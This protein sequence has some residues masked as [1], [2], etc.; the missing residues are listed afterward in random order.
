MKLLQLFSVT[1]AKRVLP[2]S[3]MVSHPS[4]QSK[5]TREKKLRQL[6]TSQR[7]RHE[8]A[9]EPDT[10]T[11]IRKE[12]MSLFSLSVKVLIPTFPLLNVSLFYFSAAGKPKTFHHLF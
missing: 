4:W 3:K 1:E 8:Q 5:S 2:N 12:M 11:E 9:R 7:T 10:E 6:R